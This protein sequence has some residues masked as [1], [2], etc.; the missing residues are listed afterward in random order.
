MHVDANCTVTQLHAERYAYTGVS[1]LLLLQQDFG[2]TSVSTRG[3]SNL[4]GI[5]NGH[6]RVRVFIRTSPSTRQWK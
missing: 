2:G 5:A 4:S 1:I 6:S 3:L